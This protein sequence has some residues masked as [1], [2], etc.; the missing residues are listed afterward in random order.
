MFDCECKLI[1]QYFTDLSWSL[2]L[3]YGLFYSV[4]KIQ[5]W[6]Y[7]LVCRPRTTIAIHHFASTSQEKFLILVQLL[8]LTICIQSAKFL[9]LHYLPLSFT[10][11]DWILI[12]RTNPT[13]LVL[14]K[15][16][17]PEPVRRV[18]TQY[19]I[20]NRGYYALE[21]SLACSLGHKSV[22]VSMWHLDTL[23]EHYYRPSKNVTV[24]Y[25]HGV[26][27]KQTLEMSWPI[28]SSQCS[29]WITGYNH[30]PCC[31]LLS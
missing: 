23:C 4:K 27:P 19:P 28:K 1:V 21:E 2:L 31:H 11:L 3:I 26:D 8:C 7:F 17:R 14:K 18:E 9:S 12:I 30:M 13:R 25:S 15:K 6:F 20:V 22:K 24:A 29:V 5:I 16:K 10:I